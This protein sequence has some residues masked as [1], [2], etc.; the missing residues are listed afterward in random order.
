MPRFFSIILC[1]GFCLAISAVAADLKGIEVD[2]LLAKVGREAI[3]LSDIQRY[4][5]VD[6]V[7]L[8]AGVYKREKPLPAERKALLSAYI[9]EE[10]MYLEA[11]AKKIN[12]DGQIP[13]SVQ[14]ILS[15]DSCRA[16]WLSLGDRFTKVFRTESR[17]REGEGLLV[18]ELEKRVLV[19]SFRKKEIM[20]DLELWKREASVRYPVKVYLE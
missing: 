6:K 15:K 3:L 2:A 7:L 12:T 10:L 9:D 19:E 17:A 16:K 13:L 1:S 8:C 4:F 18:R 11:R 5:E 20:P 14:L